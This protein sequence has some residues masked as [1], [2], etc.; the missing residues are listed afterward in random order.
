VDRAVVV[1]SPG[2]VIV[3]VAQTIGADLVVV[4]G[5]GLGMF[6]RLLLGSVSEHVLRHA[7]CPVLLVK[8]AE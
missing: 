1:G 5:K 7:P 3:Q 6:G 8:M 4:G 2:D